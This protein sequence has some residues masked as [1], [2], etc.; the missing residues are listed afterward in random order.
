MASAASPSSVVKGV[1]EG[2]G[3]LTRGIR[4]RVKSIE[5]GADPGSWLAVTVFGDHDT[6]LADGLP[7]PLADLRDRVQV[8]VRRA[9]ADKGTEIAA[10]V[11]DSGDA[12]ASDDA[13][14][15]HD[16][17]RQALRESKQLLET[18]QV[19]RVDPQPAGE[20]SSS[21]VGKAIDV[22]QTHGR[23]KGVL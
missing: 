12:D 18:G 10:R 16:R 14:A 9:P 15:L 11:I 20:R 21:P 8:D 7:A 5:P 6:V 4:E 22:A 19:M 23:D 2:V 17:L 3:H 1:R 13:A